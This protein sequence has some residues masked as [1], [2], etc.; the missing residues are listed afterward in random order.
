MALQTDVFASGKPYALRW[1]QL[2]ERGW[3]TVV[4]QPGVEANDRP[5]I[6]KM[7]RALRLCFARGVSIRGP[8][9][10]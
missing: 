2:C 8:V 9:H 5:V 4:N 3:P 1:L 7:R 6:G 10:A